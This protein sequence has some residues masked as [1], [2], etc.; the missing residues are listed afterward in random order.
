MKIVSCKFVPVLLLPDI[1]PSSK[2]K[3]YIV[4]YTS[5]KCLINV[6]SFTIIFNTV[7]QLA[8]YC[9]GHCLVCTYTNI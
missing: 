1:F 4:Y 5:L 8:S 6:I 9:V 3:V 7:K 2:L